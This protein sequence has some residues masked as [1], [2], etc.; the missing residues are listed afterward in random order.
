ML[1]KRSDYSCF[2][3]A[4]HGNHDVGSRIIRGLEITRLLRDVGKSIERVV[5][6]INTIRRARNHRAL[7]GSVSAWRLSSTRAIAASSAAIR[8]S[9]RV[10][11]SRK[12]LAHIRSISHWGRARPDRR[13]G[14]TGSLSF[15]SIASGG[16]LDAAAMALRHSDKLCP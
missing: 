2:V 12:A 1:N 4:H 8:A 11:H 9:S 5:G 3:A 14:V 15:C 7:P 10:H 13:S 6:T 16:P